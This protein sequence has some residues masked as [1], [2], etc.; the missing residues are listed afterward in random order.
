MSILDKIEQFD[1][2]IDI[3]ST[4]IKYYTHVD[5]DKQ[6]KELYGRNKLLLRPLKSHMRE[7][8]EDLMTK[9]FETFWRSLDKHHKKQYVRLALKHSKN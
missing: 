8:K 1:K 2:L 5:Y 4:V 3:M 6:M 9:N 7:N